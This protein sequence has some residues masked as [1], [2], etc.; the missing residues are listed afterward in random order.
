MCSYDSIWMILKYYS[1]N[2]VFFFFQR[3]DRKIFYFKSCTF[4]V[5]KNITQVVWWDGLKPGFSNIGKLQGKVRGVW[6]DTEQEV[7]TCFTVKF[8]YLP[9]SQTGITLKYIVNNC[10]KYNTVRFLNVLQTMGFCFH[11]FGIFFGPSILQRLIRSQV[12]NML[13]TS[14]IF[15]CDRWRLYNIRKLKLF[16]V[17]KTYVYL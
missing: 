17:Q 7:I 11:P 8:Q 16:L 9:F 4:S 3:N 2:R 10:P 15:P 5:V 14:Y 12:E 13:R 6:G 1:I